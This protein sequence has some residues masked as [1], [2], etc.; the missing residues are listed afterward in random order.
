MTTLSW[1][2][3]NE[4]FPKGLFSFVDKTA[5]VKSGLPRVTEVLFLGRQIRMGLPYNNTGGCVYTEKVEDDD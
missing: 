1:G 2:L 5:E 4:R 3:S